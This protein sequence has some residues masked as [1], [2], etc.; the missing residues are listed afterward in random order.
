[1]ASFR[2]SG[3]PRVVRAAHLLAVFA[4]TVSMVLV[5]AAPVLAQRAPA[6]G[7][8]AA[9]TS[10]DAPTAGGATPETTGSGTDAETV[11]S[12]P[13]PTQSAP[14]GEEPA[15]EP[16]G[17]VVVRRGDAPSETTGTERVTSNPTPTQSAPTGDGPAAETDGDVA[18]DGDATSGTTAT[19]SVTASAAPAGPGGGGGPSPKI[20]AKG[21]EGQK[22]VD[23]VLA[24]YTSGNVTTYTE[25]D[26]INFRFTVEGDP[27]TSGEIDVR[28]TGND[29]T[30]L[31][32]TDYF[33]FSVEGSGGTIRTSGEPVREGFGTSSGEWVQ[34][35]DAAFTTGG[36][37]VVTYRLKLSD[38]AGECNGSSQHSRLSPGGGAVSQTGEQNVPVPANQIIELP[39]ITVIKRIDRDGD[40]TFEALAAAGEYCFKLDN[41]AC[42]LTDGTG[43]VVFTNVTDGAHT[44][45]E[46]QMVFTQGTYAFV[47]GTGTNCTFTGSTATAD[48]AAGTTAKDATC[49][50]QNRVQRGKLELVKDLV[51]ATD[52]GLFNLAI[53]RGPTPVA[54]APNVSDGGTTGEQTLDTGTYTVAETAG[55][56]TVL[57]NYTSSIS[58]RNSNGTGAVVA[59]GNGAGPLNVSVTEGADIVCT[60]TNTR[61]TGKVEVVKALSP[62]DDPGR[63]DLQIDGATEAD[64]AGDGGTTDEV[65]LNTG[66]H[67]VGEAAGTGTDLADYTSSIS[68]RD[69]NGTG[70]VV[71]SGNG[72]GPLNVSVTDGADIV[73]TITNTRETGKLELVKDL[74]PATDGGL[75]NLA[76][77]QG[78]TPKAT[79]SDVGDGGTTGEQTLNTGTYTVAET[80]GTGTDLAD[81]ASSITCLDAAGATVAGPTAGSGPLNVSVT[82]GADIVCTITNTRE[83]GKL[84]LVKDLS[85]ATDPGLF[86]LAITQGA[87]TKA[88]ATDVGDGGTTGEQTLNTGTYTVAETAGTGTDLADYASSISCRGANGTGA[89]VAGPTP[90]SGPLNITL[91]DGADI[92][93]TITN[94]RPQAPPPS[95]DQGCTPGYWKNHPEAWQTYT[96]NQ[97]LESVF[98]VPN[99]LSLDDK[100][101]LQALSFEGGRGKD[102]AARVLLRAAVAALLN[103]AHQDVAYPRTTAEV[104]SAVNAALATGNRT[105]M[106]VLAAQLD[107]DNNLG[108]PL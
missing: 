36:T 51:P 59:S 19:E 84:E 39:E 61:Q 88:T 18:K 69:A 43:R 56:G 41:G 73:C 105:A 42:A 79:A 71:A 50:F 3:A 22:K 60:F 17:D 104:I 77:T 37:L 102:G 106:L 83:T 101:L 78:T 29:G 100:T 4:V 54:S 23:G 74:S 46:E 90:G 32:F 21:H 57:T 11:T 82:D 103:A 35:L 92:V 7:A 45:T 53:S 98:D 30:C 64:D 67:T 75:F 44:V 89:T 13:T 20:T 5:A 72:A 86:N 16:K 38:Q 81:Y 96:T 2:R 94:T 70:A 76:I 107:T 93:C 31:F 68:C 87:I 34:T 55:I 66:T 62:S 14:T 8:P 24:G 10:G 99:S 85:P 6:E 9:E 47:S 40:G 65:T 58:C 1:M 48:V 91:G 28:F 49:T 33:T 52:G 95:P 63:F 27:N 26:Y 80:A 97:S 15:A 108:C 12:N 25:G